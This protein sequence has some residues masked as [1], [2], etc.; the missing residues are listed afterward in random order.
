MYL[1]KNL[2]RARCRCGCGLFFLDGREDRNPHAQL[3][4]PSGVYRITKVEGQPPYTVWYYGEPAVDPDP[5]RKG[6][7]L[8]RHG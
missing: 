3:A 8:G 2:G 6:T 1:G 4:V 5:G 7:I